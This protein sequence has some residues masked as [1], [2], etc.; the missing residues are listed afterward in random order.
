MKDIENIADIKIFVDEFYEKVRHDALLAPVFASKISDAEWPAHLNRLYA[1]WNAILF[2]ERG[3]EG[4]PMQKHFALPISENH[5]SQWLHLFSQTIDSHFSGP[6][7][8]EAK[9]RATSIAQ[10]MQFKLS[11][12]IH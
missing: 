11:S 8:A 2:A 6:K 10:I 4:N 7:A 5:F 9:Q 12:R 3:F 1:F